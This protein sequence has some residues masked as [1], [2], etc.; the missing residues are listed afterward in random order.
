[1]TRGNSI[2]KDGH[3]NGTKDKADKEDNDDNEDTDKKRQSMYG[4]GN[5]N[6]RAIKGQ[7][8]K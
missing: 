8:G 4:K 1:M 3:D 7:G 5:V 6:T 2:N